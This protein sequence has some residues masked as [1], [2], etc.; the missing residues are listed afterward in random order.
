MKLIHNLIEHIDD[1][2]EGAK[3][4]A[5]KYIDC[6]ARGNMTRAEKYSEMAKDELKHASYIKEFAMSDIEG[7]KAVYNL[8]DEIETI[9]EHAHKRFSENMAMV[10]Q[11]LNM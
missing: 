1:E 11:M 7:I 5:E 2:I 4:Y 3:E 10:R 8:P 9:W 6:K